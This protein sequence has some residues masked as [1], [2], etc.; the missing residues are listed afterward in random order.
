MLKIL[1]SYSREGRVGGWMGAIEDLQSDAVLASYQN[2]TPHA[3]N[4]RSLDRRSAF[5]TS[6]FFH[7]LTLYYEYGNVTI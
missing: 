5:H 1:F 7:V 3:L 6:F 2:L 4:G